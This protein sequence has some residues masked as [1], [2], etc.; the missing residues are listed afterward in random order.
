MK[1][2]PATSRRRSQGLSLIETLVGLAIAL[3]AMLI[4]FQVFS[5]SGERSRTTTSG[6]DAQVAGS[7]ALF[8]LDRDLKMAGMGFGLLPP[9]GVAGGVGGCTLNA[10]N[11]ALAVA[12]V[13]FPL[14]PVQIIQGVDALGVVNG[15]PAQI[16]VTYG[17]SAYFALARHFNAST[18]TS[19]KLDTRDAFQLG[20]IVLVT[21]SD[22]NNVGSCAMVEITGVPAPDD[23]FT[24]NHAQGGTY[25][26][27]YTGAGTVPTMNAAAGVNT[28]VAAT[29]F[30]YNLGPRPQRKLW[31]VRPAGAAGANLLVWNDTL[32]SDTQTQVTEGVVNLQAEYG[33]DDG[34]GAVC[35]A[36][37]LAAG[38]VAND[39]IISPTEWTIT[40]PADP[41]RLL[42]V[43]FAVLARSQQYEKTAVTTVAPFWANDAAG[44]SFTMFNVDGTADSTPGNANDWRHYRYRVYE[45]AVP[46]RNLI[47]G[48]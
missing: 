47:W 6:S 5:A 11:S 13:N 26:S 29:G 27:V 23:T 30:V 3:I 25:T 21:S 7:L 14:M 46:L 19:K 4:V 35:I 12:D 17:D 24:I 48:K 8:Q 18:T 10:Y 36:A 31:Q 39:G 44:H 41:T 32:H 22:I 15:S 16:A 1:Q 40:A 42:A 34:C 38:A 33:V 37:L 43:R 20:D 9:T 45:S 28:L 2:H